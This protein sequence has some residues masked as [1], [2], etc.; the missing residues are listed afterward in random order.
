MKKTLLLAIMLPCMVV[1]Y[2]HSMEKE[3]E[4][5]IVK[6]LPQEMQAEIATYKLKNLLDNYAADVSEKAGTFGYYVA[7][8]DMVPSALLLIQ[9]GADQNVQGKFGYTLLQLAIEYNNFNTAAYLLQH[10]A[11]PNIQN[12]NGDTALHILANKINQSL[13]SFGEF[14]QDEE[15]LLN[16]LLA[17]GARKDIKNKQDETPYDI[18]NNTLQL[19]AYN[20]VSQEQAQQNKQRVLDLLQPDNQ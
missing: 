11:N 16:L 6:D 7:F 9:T 5:I 19:N 20:Q 12:D 8:R 4:P 1:T 10:R 2:V 18:I 17:A 15:N 3:Q 14:Y 13:M